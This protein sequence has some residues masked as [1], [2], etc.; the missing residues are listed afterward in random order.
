MLGALGDKSARGLVVE[1]GLK[2]PA[3]QR[4]DVLASL[5]RS[6]GDGQPDNAGDLIPLLRSEDQSARRLAIRLAG[7]WKLRGALA[8][9]VGIASSPEQEQEDRVLASR[10]VVTIDETQGT[11]FLRQILDSTKAPGVT[12]TALAG[13][14]L[15]D[16]KDAAKRAVGFLTKGPDRKWAAVAF[17][18]LLGQKGGKQ[19]LTLALAEAKLPEGVAAEGIRVARE[20]GLEASELIG[21][22]T[23]AGGL[24]QVTKN[25]TDTEIASLLTGIR[26]RG[27]PHRGEQIFR[28]AKLNCLGCHALGGAGGH[29]GPDL[30][31]LGG[32][33]QLG[34]LLQSVVSPSAKIK[35]GYA[36]VQLALFDGRL[37]TGVV[38]KKT[39][40]S[41]QIR[42]A[43]NELVT[44]RTDDVDE[45]TASKI[46][47]MP[48]GVAQQ[49]RQDEL[50]DL[51]SYLS[52]LGREDGFRVPAKKYVRDW[53]VLEATPEM[54]KRIA[55]GDARALGGEGLVWAERF[56]TARGGLPLSEVPAFNASGKRYGYVR[57]G[58]SEGESLAVGSATEVLTGGEW[59][60]VR[61]GTRVEPNGGRGVLLRV[62]LSEEAD[63]EFFAER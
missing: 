24:K 22:L 52:A 57:V 12:A 48:D 39:P 14:A 53:E 62:S 35:E 18:S 8:L 54:T 3:G 26:D 10:A 7:R 5:L 46:S 15:V 6:P 27:D 9:L 32:S 33:A 56:S 23:K 44:V 58:L 11:T 28:R 59:R 29:V 2:L 63:A 50:I 40:E 34:D 47:L 4:A 36:S 45:A 61:E 16:A 21:A 51:V 41:I 42:T 20:S 13:W 55:A 38:T 1:R 31:S 25:L 30:S 17:E 43:K 60:A 37:M 19:S 49:L